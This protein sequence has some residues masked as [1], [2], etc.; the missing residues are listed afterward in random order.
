MT[1]VTLELPFPPSTNHIWRRA[2]GKNRSKKM[3]LSEGALRY[4]AFV[5]LVIRHEVLIGDR[6]C[7]SSLPLTER[8]ALE[9]VLHPVDKKK[10]DL[11]NFVKSVQ[12]ALTHAGV[13]KDDSQIDDLRV[14]RGNP[15]PGYPHL[16][17][18][19][20]TDGFTGESA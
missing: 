1:S 13:W 18:R 8:I 11:D 20:T 14:I 12:D 4:R 6:I 10:R 9:I 3:M 5:A 2:S 15:N 7:A 17:V 16:K 19:I